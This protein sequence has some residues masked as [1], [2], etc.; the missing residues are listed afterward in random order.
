[1][2][3]GMAKRMYNIQLIDS[4]NL[5]SLDPKLQ[6]FYK[7]VSSIAQKQNLPLPEIGVYESAEA[8]A[9]ATGPSKSS[10]LVAASTGLL[11]QMTTQE[12]EGVM[13]HEMS[14]ISN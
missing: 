9:F 11:A 8:N 10:S 14:H 13:G 3:K 7:I 6:E 12:V 4:T 5:S 1:M 2:S